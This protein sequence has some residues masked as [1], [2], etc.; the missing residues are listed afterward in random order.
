[1]SLGTLIGQ[2]YNG[3]V[4]PVIIGIGFLIGLAILVERWSEIKQQ[5]LEMRSIEIT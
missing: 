2:R 5:K 3:T 1:M 4:L